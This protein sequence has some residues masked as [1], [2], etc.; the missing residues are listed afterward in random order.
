MRLL[1]W[2]TK[3]AEV[4]QT[5]GA[6]FMLSMGPGSYLAVQAQY[7]D[8]ATEG[9]LY[10]SIANACINRIATSIA[11]V[12]PHLYKRTKGGKLEKVESHPLL[13]LL[14]N[15]N[16]A[17][18]GKEFME[19]LVSYFYVGG[20]AYIYGNRGITGKLKQP[21]ELQLLN[22]GQMKVQ[23]GSGL[24][25]SYYEYR[26]RP[27]QD[28]IRYSV[29]QNTGY[30]PVLQLKTFNPLSPWE[31]ISPM[32]AAAFGIDIF[33]S[34]NKWNKRLLDNDA[35]PSGAL[36][37]KNADGSAQTLSEEQYQ[38]L[39]EMID[40]Q[41][42][43]GS[44]AGRPL[45]LEGGLDWKEMSVNPK[46]LDFLNGKNSAATDIGL[47]FG[48]PSQLIGIPGSSTFANYEQAM[49]A[50]WTDTVIPRLCFILEA[51]N[52]WLTPLYGDDLYL[53]YDEEMIPALEPRRK[54]KADRINNSNYMTTNEKRRAM[55]LD[56]VEG[57]DAILVP[58]NQ[59]PLDLISESTRLQE[60]GAPGAPPANTDTG[61]Q[62]S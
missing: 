59:I 16:P 19:W 47:T 54:E 36:V 41:M 56:D 26:P 25:P 48:V 38:R 15:P 46:D 14:E 61:T 62:S 40:Q 57:G 50:F 12:E 55:G 29:D 52:R 31:G 21:T 2:K 5:K 18:S 4:A 37:V 11:S 32:M 8:L 35:R 27:Q 42:S 6:S 34:G 49:L 23:P 9:Y 10:N 3:K 53:W 13:D 51:L 45:L 33:N 60:P 20:N 58:F 44:N 7:K 22:P 30:S 39:K 1:P 28:A 43:G 24:F 17:Q